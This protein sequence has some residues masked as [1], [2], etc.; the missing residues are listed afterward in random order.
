MLLPINELYQ[1][2]SQNEIE[3]LLDFYDEIKSY[4]I[5]H[6][7]ILVKG[8]ETKIPGIIFNFSKLD[9]PITDMLYHIKERYPFLGTTVSYIITDKIIPKFNL[10]SHTDC[11][12]H[13]LTILQSD[14]TSQ[15]N[16]YKIKKAPGFLNVSELI[17][18]VPHPDGEVE[19]WYSK[20]L[21][22][23][24]TYLFDSHTFHSV[25]NFNENTRIVFAWW[26]D[27]IAYQH[28]CEYYGKNKFFNR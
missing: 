8:D 1:G 20:I 11:H 22:Q 14:N 25:E 19:H 21:L 18:I 9:H 28:A 3:K 23:G 13:L 27:H 12:C 17:G 15:T 4:D 16:W 10:H 24:K 26:L 2:F 5:N 6:P 7:S